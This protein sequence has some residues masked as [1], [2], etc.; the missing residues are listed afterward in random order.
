MKKILLFTLI[1]FVSLSGTTFGQ[2]GNLNNTSDEI[3]QVMKQKLMENLNLDE[4]TADKYIALHKENNKQLKGLMKEKRELMRSINSNP[5][6]AD[7]ESKLNSFL[8]LDSKIVELRKNHISELKAFLTPQQIAKSM[9][10]TRK[11]NKELR[12]QM[13]ER[14][15]NRQNNDSQNNNKQNNDINK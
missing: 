4:S 14:K 13:R 6:A 1:L 12:N 11:F 7:I 3:G 10:F 5:D 15:R 9:I 2:R 8:D